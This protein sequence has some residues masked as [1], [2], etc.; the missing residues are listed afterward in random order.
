MSLGN[1]AILLA[2]IATIII[3]GNSKTLSGS[4]EVVN[5][6]NFPNLSFSVSGNG[7]LTFDETTGIIEILVDGILQISAVINA[8]AIQASGDFIMIPEYNEQNGGWYPSAPRKEVLT[9]IKP[10]QVLLQGSKKFLKNDL[11]RFNTYAGSGSIALKT[12]IV[13]QGG[14]LQTVL[15][16]AILYFTMNRVTA[17]LK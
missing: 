9:A 8:L 12:E 17:G 16:S 3:T 6:V 1:N 11:I 5:T 10:T 14:P 13:N 2:R 4:P 15:P 7:L